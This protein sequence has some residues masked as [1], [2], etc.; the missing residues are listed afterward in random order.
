MPDTTALDQDLERRQRQL[1]QLDRLAQRFG[2][3]LSTAF[4]KNAADGRR[5]DDGVTPSPQSAPVLA[6]YLVRGEKIA[7]SDR[8]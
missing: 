2:T 4:A 7:S 1:E 5:L 8:P 6:C 3:S